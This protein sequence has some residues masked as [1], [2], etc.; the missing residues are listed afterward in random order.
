MYE[1]KRRGTGE[2]IGRVDPAQYTPI[3][4]RCAQCGRDLSPI[5]RMMGPVCGACCRKN[6][7]EATR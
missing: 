3:G 1:I 4:T 2:V 6:H 5:D 7:R